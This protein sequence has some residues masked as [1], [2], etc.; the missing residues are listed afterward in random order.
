MRF[1]SK[2]EETDFNNETIIFPSSIIV[3][4]NRIFSGEYVYENQGAG[5]IIY[6]N[7]NNRFLIKLYFY[8]H[9]Y[10]KEIQLQLRAGKLAPS[11]R[12]YRHIMIAEHQLGD[13]IKYVNNNQPVFIVIMDYLSPS[14]GWV[15]LKASDDTTIRLLSDINVVRRLIKSVYELVVVKGMA[16]L[17]DFVGYT[18]DHIFYNMETNKFQ[19]I[20]YG[21]FNIIKKDEAFAS[22]TGM[23]HLID[24]RFL[25]PHEDSQNKNTILRLSK[26]EFKQ[27]S[28]LNKYIL[29]QACKYF[30]EKNEM[31]N[32]GRRSSQTQTRKK[33]QRSSSSSQNGTR[34]KKSRH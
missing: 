32:S 12:Y 14:N 13:R 33:Q 17:V 27:P 1:K 6:L 4:R 11:I 19:F 7:R 5:G 9:S 23:I 29:F 18:G 34:N 8:R 10:E 30:Y 22:F 16:N 3:E 15:P 21:Q 24:S 26:E 2:F 31:R 28:E 25:Y 20:D